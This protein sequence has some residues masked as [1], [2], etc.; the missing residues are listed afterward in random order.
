MKIIELLIDEL[1]ELT[2]FDAVA[3]VNQ[4]AIEAGFHAFN[5]KEVDDAIAFQVIKSAMKDQF[6][7]RLPGESQDDYLGRCI[8]KLIGEGYDQDQATAICYDSLSLS[9][10]DKKKIEFESYTDYPESATN[11]AKRALEW[12]DGHPDQ[13]CGTRVGWARAN[14]LANREPISEETIARMASFARHLQH[15]DVPYSEGCGGLMVDA[16]G[17]R[18]GIEWAS[19]KLEEIREGLSQEFNHFDNLPI[20]IQEKLLETLADKGFSYKDIEE[21]YEILDSPKETFG[22]PTKSSA[23]PDGYTN[24][25]RGSYKILYQYKVSPGKGAPIQENS[26]AFCKRLI[27]LNLLFRKEDIDRMTVTGANSEEFGVYDIFTYKGSYNCRHYWKK[28]YV[29]QK[30]EGVGLLEVAGLLL[31]QSAK[32]IEDAGGGPGN[33]QSPNAVVAFGK[34]FKFV[35]DGDQMRVVGPLMIPEKLIFRVDEDNEPYFVYFSQDTIKKIAYKMMKEKRLDEVNLE[36]DQDTKVS[37]YLEESWIIED[38]ESDKQNAF[39]FNFPKGTWMGQ[40]KIED[41]E[42]WKMVKN[43]TL[44]GFSI[45]GYF[46]DRLVQN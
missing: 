9:S 22:L 20:N 30:K 42:V 18:A 1:E 12:R 34:Q 21:E 43:G 35:T 40:Y 6:V 13:G 32:N 26:R 33:V 2:G 15:E 4:P 41:P 3:L 19:N 31:D 16:W 25:T 14:Q 39:G 8:P 36:H 37:G 45:E 38:P 29:Y 5:S 11:A 7:D 24:D 17:G 44:T 46:A 28:V 27:D 10:E 23:N